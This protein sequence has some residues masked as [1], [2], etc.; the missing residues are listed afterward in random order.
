MQAMISVENI[1]YKYKGSEKWAIENVSFFVNK[2]ETL[3]LAG[4]T[5]S[6]KSTVIKAIIGLIPGFYGGE[7]RGRVVVDGLQVNGSPIKSVIQKVGYVPQNP[8]NHFVTTTVESDVAFM[9]EN[10][11]MDC[12]MIRERVEWSLS[13]LG[14]SNLKKRPIME[15][16]EGQKQKVAIAG[17]IAHEPRVLLL[18]EPTGFMDTE[19][20]QDLLRA[21][22][23]LKRDINITVIIAEHRVKQLMPYVDRVLF[24]N[25]GRIQD[26]P[27]TLE[28][29]YRSAEQPCVVNNG[30]STAVQLTGVYYSY[31]EGFMVLKGIDLSIRAGELLFI[32]GPNGSGK[33]TFLRIMGGIY[34]PIKGSVY[35][36]GM[37]ISHLNQR[38]ISRMI[39]I[40]P[41]NPDHALFEEKVIDEI[42]FGAKN[43][44]V[45]APYERAKR[46][47]ELLNVFTLLSRSP[48][49]LSWGEKK[50]VSIASVVASNPEIIAI[51]EPT[52]GQDHK[53]RKIIADAVSTLLRIGKT[54][55]IATHDLELISSFSGARVVTIKD[56][57]LT[58]DAPQTKSRIQRTV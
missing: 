18:D 2:G 15:L 47:A 17:A 1:S 3:L 30:T 16:S 28:K 46:A 4:Y 37:D 11:G 45:D 44:G 52:A 9:L 50:R 43:L 38:A 13:L 54:V 5:G 58:H 19:G 57:K 22:N 7:F 25:E 12:D 31:R 33:S 14:I 26:A 35:I 51:D 6:G 24:M 34:K 10:L 56:G 41:Q 32:L 8:D 23:K 20:T 49:E 48:L 53:N 36:N 42:A 29:L 40:V 27:D 39:G 55:I 21:V